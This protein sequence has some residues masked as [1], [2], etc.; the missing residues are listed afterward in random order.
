[1]LYYYCNYYTMCIIFNRNVSCGQCSEGVPILWDFFERGYFACYV[2]NNERNSPKNHPETRGCVFSS[3]RSLNAESSRVFFSNF[4]FVAFPVYRERKSWTGLNP[5]IKFLNVVDGG[6]R[7]K[8]HPFYDC[9]VDVYISLCVCVRV[10]VCV[11]RVSV[12]ACM[13]RV[14]T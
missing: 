3:C 5:L 6:W 11:L 4:R 10:C 12:C 1:M 8:S 9:K 7:I 13:L 2:I 14:G